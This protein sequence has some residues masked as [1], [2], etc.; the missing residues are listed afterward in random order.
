[1]FLTLK[2]MTLLT[3]QE[4]AKHADSICV[5][6]V[7]DGEEVLP[8]PERKPDQHEF[9]GWNGTSLANIAYVELNSKHKE[10]RETAQQI[11]AAYLDWNM[12]KK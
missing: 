8:L 4:R 1:M 6:M 10:E 3:L 7:D 9:E 12:N 5:Q 11:R 2:E